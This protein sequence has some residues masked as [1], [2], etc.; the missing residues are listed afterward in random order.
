MKPYGK[1]MKTNETLRKAKGKPKEKL[2][3][4]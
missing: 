3:K 4:T 1:Q 2:K